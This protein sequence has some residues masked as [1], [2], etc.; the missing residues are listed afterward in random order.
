MQ[1]CEA[2]L[3]PQEKYTEGFFLGRHGL[4]LC[5]KNPTFVLMYQVNTDVVAVVCEYPEG[6]SFEVGR[7]KKARRDPLGRIP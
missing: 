4:G 6:K 2:I 1:N 3:Q 5:P 7:R